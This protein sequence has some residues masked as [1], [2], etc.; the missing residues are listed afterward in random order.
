MP[1]FSAIPPEGLHFLDGSY[2]LLPFEGKMIYLAKWLELTFSEH[3]ACLTAAQC[4][5]SQTCGEDQGRGCLTDV[6]AS[7]S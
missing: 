3:F 2:I 7:L 1:S 5:A 4:T 6:M